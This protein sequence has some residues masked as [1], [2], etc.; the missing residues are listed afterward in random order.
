MSR[1]HPLLKKRDRALALLALGHS[2]AEAAAEVGVSAAAVY[3]WRRGPEYAISETRRRSEQRA[4]DRRGSAKGDGIPLD[5]RDWIHA[6]ILLD[7][8]CDLLE[9]IRRS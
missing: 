6:P 1:G 7:L 2:V 5:L 4:R 8:V 9:E 3:K